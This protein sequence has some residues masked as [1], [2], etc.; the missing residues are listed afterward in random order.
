MVVADEKNLS[1]RN[2]QQNKNS[3][4]G[5]VKPAVMLRVVANLC[6]MNITLAVGTTKQGEEVVLVVVSGTTILAALGTAAAAAALAVAAAVA[7]AL[8]R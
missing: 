4:S 3:R 8:Q 1:P 5:L 6:H 2:T 7:V